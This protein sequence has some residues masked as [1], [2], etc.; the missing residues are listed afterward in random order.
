MFPSGGRGCTRAN[1]KT[2]CVAATS[3]VEDP[4]VHG[5]GRSRDLHPAQASGVPVAAAA[6]AADVACVVPSAAVLHT[7]I[8]SA[9]VEV[10]G[11]VWCTQAGIARQL[12]MFV[13]RMAREAG[14]VGHAALAFMV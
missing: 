13:V 7:E 11:C 8:L 12:R 1:E 4:A 5:S 3:L 10:R 9:H 6:A 2:G 14:A